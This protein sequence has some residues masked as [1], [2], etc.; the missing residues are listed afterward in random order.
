MIKRTILQQRENDFFYPIR[1]KLSY[2][3]LLLNAAQLL[4][5]EDAYEDSSGDNAFMKLVVGKMRRVFFYKKE[6]YFS[7]AF[8]LIVRTDQSNV[9]EILT[10][11]NKKLNHSMIS[12]MKSILND[13]NFRNKPSLRD[14]PVDETDENNDAIYLLEE[15][16]LFEPSYIRYDCDTKNQN[17]AIH[18]LYHLDINYSQYGTYK[19]GL[20]SNIDNDYFENIQNIETECLFL[21]DKK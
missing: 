5:L 9:T 16:L 15:I 8:P 3:L 7:V 20:C 13:Q 17:G 10:D 4:L 12:H 11:T 6:K 18:P 1:D 19:L 21:V 14:Y 2:A